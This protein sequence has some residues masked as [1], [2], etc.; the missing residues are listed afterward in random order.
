MQQFIAYTIIGLTIGA[1]YALASSGLVLT[2]VTSGV[3]NIA[4]GAIGMISA[5]VY[6]QIR[7]D[8]GVPTPLARDRARSL[9]P[10]ARHVH[11]AIRPA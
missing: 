5:F 11:R 4:H 1:I 3:F 7:F 8:W 2:Y 10:A 6:W 9:L